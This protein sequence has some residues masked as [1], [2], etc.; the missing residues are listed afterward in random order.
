MDKE[1]VR[2]FLHQT[3]ESTWADLEAIFRPSGNQQLTYPCIVY[4]AK[5]EEPSFANN[6][7]YI[8][9]TR[10]QVSFLYLR[11]DYI[12]THPIYSLGPLGITVSSS[13]NFI[14][15]DV[16]HDIFDVSVHKI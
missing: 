13:R 12:N 8:I 14:D 15:D 10:F 7:G 4:E 11:S 5:E 9:G 16:V 2:L 6:L 3:L 1:E